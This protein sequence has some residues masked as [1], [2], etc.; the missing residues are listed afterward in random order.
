[1]QTWQNFLLNIPQRLQPSEGIERIHDNVWLI[2]LEIGL[3]SLSTLIEQSAL[4][5]IHIRLLFLEESPDWRVFP[6][7]AKKT[8]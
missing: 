1:M 2:D 5:N 6:P 8:E 7:I 3:R 4:R